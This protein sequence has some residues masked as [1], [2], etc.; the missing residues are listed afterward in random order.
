[1][2]SFPELQGD[3]V[4]GKAKTWTIRVIEREIGGCMCGVIETTHGYVDGKKQVNEKVIERG[5]NI[6]RSNET[7]AV[8]QAINDARAAW[9]KKKES[10]YSPVGIGGGG[11]EE[12][13]DEDVVGGGRSKGID[14]DVP[15]P[16]LAHDYHKRGKSIKYPC[17]VQRKYDGTR[18]VAMPGKGLYSR[19]K[20]RYPHLDH[21]IAE[22]NRLPPTVVLD[23]ELYSD[24]LTFQEIVGLVKRETLKSGDEEKQ[25]QIKFHVYDIVNDMPYAQ[26]WANLQMLFKRYKFKHLVLVETEECESE[27]QMKELHG[28]YVGEGKEGL[29]LRNKDGLYKNARSCDLQKYKEFFDGEFKIVDYK[30]GEGLEAGCVIWVCETEEGKQFACRPRGTREERCEWYLRGDEYLGKMLTVRYQEMTDA[31]VPRFPV[32]IGTRDYE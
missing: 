5:K 22:V 1:M 29:M 27:E 11:D 31:N 8:Q 10:G 13:G 24:T 14:E 7:S 32:A 19:N 30:E 20:K 9:V 16:M 18:C 21:I 4:N 23:G 26:R 2:A 12:E 15:S 3:A 25:L 28:R 6:S 17:F